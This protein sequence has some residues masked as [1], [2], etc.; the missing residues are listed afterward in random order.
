MLEVRLLFVV[1]FIITLAKYMHFLLNELRTVERDNVAVS[2]CFLNE[3]NEKLVDLFSTD[4]NDVILIR[5]PLIFDS[6]CVLCIR[7]HPYFR[8]E[9]WLNV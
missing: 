1:K 9:I 2:S 6:F 4:I 5:G 7:L 8:H 3:V